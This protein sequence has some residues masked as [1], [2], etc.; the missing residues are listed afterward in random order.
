SKEREDLM[1]AFGD[2][3]E[4]LDTNYGKN[5][6]TQ[7]LIIRYKAYI[8]AT[9]LD[10][11]TGAKKIWDSVMSS[12][13]REA[14]FWLEYIRLLRQV[15]DSNGCRKVF[16]RAIQTSNDNPEL[17]CE[18]YL[19]FEKEEG[20][21]SD[22]D[23]AVT[24]C[25][26][27]LKRAWEQKTREYEKAESA[28]LAEEEANAKKEQ[29]KAQKRAQKKAEIKSKMEK[30]KRKHEKDDERDKESGEPEPKRPFVS[31]EELSTK[32]KEEDVKETSTE[33]IHD[34]SKDPQTVFVSNLLFT[35][36]EEQ[37]KSTFSPLGEIEEIRLVKNLQ[38]A[39]RGYAYVQFKNE[40]SVSAAL[41]IDRQEL[42]GRPMYVSR[43]VDKTRNPTTFK[44]PT[45]LDKCTVFVTNLPFEIKSVDIED[46]FK[47]H[48]KVKEV[49]LVTNRS[50]KSKG[51]AYIEY[52]DEVG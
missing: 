24:K 36:D 21:L 45:T 42:R 47:V 5:A 38:G 4:Y 16:T 9:K 48:G 10:N 49:R 34:R 41:A 40:S 13:T 1:K 30:T 33:K 31:K 15:N 14:Q 46:V 18:S 27:R 2:A 12:H 22:L 28:R 35:V 50:G 26:A 29:H 39:S 11:V 43:C 6:D 44:F 51:Y 25:S 7:A 32:S 23:T 3:T 8:E 19:K 52:E 17:L 20:S 37:L